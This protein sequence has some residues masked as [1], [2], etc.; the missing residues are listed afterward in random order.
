MD[1][2]ISGQVV[3][4]DGNV[5]FAELGVSLN[6]SVLLSSGKSYGVAITYSMGN[7]AAA[8]PVYQNQVYE[9]NGLYF[10]SDA[11][12]ALPTNLG[13]GS[14]VLQAYYVRQDEGGA[15]R[16]SDPA[17][18]RVEDFATITAEYN[19]TIDGTENTYTATYA[20]VDNALR[21]VVDI[22]DIEAPEI[23]INGAGYDEITNTITYRFEKS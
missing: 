6:R 23:I 11:S 1:N 5:S 15:I 3:V 10:E 20:C 13:P 9:G 2:C 18:I 14:Y 7:A 16:I 22:K 12:F 19:L 8:L 4:S 17:T 21:I